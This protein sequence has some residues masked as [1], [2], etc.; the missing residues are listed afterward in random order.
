MAS[1]T[2]HTAKS[3]PAEE[4]RS[5]KRKELSTPSDGYVCKICGNGGHWIQQCP[6][7]KKRK[8]NKTAHEYVK[9]V[10]PSPADI[11]KAKEMQQLPRPNCYCGMASR[12]KKVKKSKV[13]EQSRANGSYFFFCSKPRADPTRCTFAKPVEDDQNSSKEKKSSNFFAKK[14]M[15]HSTPNSGT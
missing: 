10:D 3:A 5:A 15:K 6:E 12:L 8:K 14:R 11:E 9:G 4:S 2:V 13:K 1:S 7:K